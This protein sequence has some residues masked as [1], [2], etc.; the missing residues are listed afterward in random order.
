M[1]RG[2]Q[3]MESQV[4]RK[5]QVTYEPEKYIIIEE[6]IENGKYVKK[7]MPAIEVCEVL[8][9]PDMSSYEKIRYGLQTPDKEI[10]SITFKISKGNPRPLLKEEYAPKRQ[11]S[12]INKGDIYHLYANILSESPIYTNL[13]EGLPFTTD[14]HLQYLE[15]NPQNMK[16]GIKVGSKEL[17]IYATKQSCVSCGM[18]DYWNVEEVKIKNADR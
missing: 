17:E 9:N 7:E 2:I 18:F 11:K 8:Y 13:P 10:A 12:Q 6:K 5:L 4:P 15:I 16:L 1:Y 14:I 3:I